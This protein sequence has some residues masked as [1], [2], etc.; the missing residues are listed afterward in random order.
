MIHADDAL[1]VNPKVTV[2]LVNYNGYNDTVECVKSLKQIEYDNYEIIVVN[3]GSTYKPIE[4]QQNYLMEHTVYVEINDNLGFSGGN[5]IGIR[6]AIEN[7]SDYVLL[8][9]NDTVVTPDCL[10]VMV[11][12][13]EKFEDVGAIGGKINFLNRQDLIWYGGGSY[14]FQKGNVK[15]WKYNQKDCK[16]EENVQEV[17]FITGCLMLIPISVIDVVGL[18]DES[19]FLYAEDLEL[20]CRILKNKYKL[21]YCPDAQIYHKV[22]A[23][24]GRKS[25]LTQYYM[26]R[27]NLYVVKMYGTQHIL[28]YSFHF[29]HSVA[30]I[31]KG[32]LNFY[33]IAC[34]WIDFFRNK[35]GIWEGNRQQV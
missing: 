34:A 33:P 31:I 6:M 9:N 13:A 24:T 8:L 25:Y 20:C 35:K 11:E 10:Q 15:H 12:T 21:L 29:I 4:W 30:R 22:S 16:S 18:L 23:S 7:K 17:S 26:E 27:N 1:F 5:N 32:K 3:N 14:D 28:A 19:F 2:I